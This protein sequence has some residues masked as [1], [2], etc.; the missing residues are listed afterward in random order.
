[1]IY[2]SDAD[3]EGVSR[4]TARPKRRGGARPFVQLYDLKSDPHELKD[5]ARDPTN[6]KIVQTLQKKLHAW[7][8]SVDY[9]VRTKFLWTE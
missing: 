2:P 1:M 3:P 7:M 8:K 6:A 5:V 9:A 4:H